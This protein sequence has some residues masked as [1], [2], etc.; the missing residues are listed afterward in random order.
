MAASGIFGILNN[1]RVRTRIY[2][3]FGII[4][5]LMGA[6]AASGVVGLSSGRDG[7][8]SV[9]GIAQLN[10][11]V[12]D[13]EAQIIEM[14][15]SVQEYIVSGN[16]AKRQEAET[17]RGAIKAR[18]DQASKTLADIQ[19][20]ITAMTGDVSSESQTKTS[21]AAFSPQ[22]FKAVDEVMEVYGRE[23]Q[24]VVE[25]RSR[26]N[27]IL[28]EKIDQAGPAAIKAAEEILAAEE[29]VGNMATAAIAA[30]LV[31]ELWSMS[32]NASRFAFAGEQ[33]RSNA[34]RD[35][36]G[37]IDQLVEQIEKATKADGTKGLIEQVREHVGAFEGGFT[38]MMV[39]N[40]TI[41][42]FIQ[43]AQGDYN[44]RFAQTIGAIKAS[45]LGTQAAVE[46]DT[47]THLT[48][49]LLLTYLLCGACLIVGL[50]SAVLVVR[51][52]VGPVGEISK[53]MTHLADGNL[54]VEIPGTGQK[55]EFGDMAR[56]A[57]VF[58]ANAQQT[59]KLVDQVTQSARQVALASGQAS[60]AVGQVS[61][62]SHT[63]LKALQQVAAALEQS[64]Q[65]IANVAES[66]QEASHKAKKAARLVAEGRQL[67]GSMV[68]EVNAISSN[69]GQ[70]SKITDAI[71]RIANQTNMLS[72]N[73]AIEAA[74]AG[75]YGRGFAV[76][77]EEI[78]KLAEHSGQ[79]AQEIA[80]L[81]K[82]A[83]DQAQ[84]G[85]AGAGKV[86]ANMLDIAEAVR[87]NDKLI[88][89][90]ATA[91]EEQQTTVS[92]IN[93]NVSELTRIGQSNAA[94]SEEITATMIDLSRL[95]EQTR[96]QAESFN[97]KDNGHR[98]AA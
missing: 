27:G 95:A 10:N 94:A 35:D 32:Y 91:M 82:K 74:R 90:I 8:A 73:A 79:L 31:S 2:G 13:I 11:L 88:G 46:A 96:G 65:A 1:T 42:D 19:G 97:N 70:I 59:H 81:V 25:L 22:Q 83:T 24:E 54:D 72:L 85:V 67:M 64:T 66:S 77:A 52:I 33:A 57:E 78:R 48:D 7:L 53:A 40:L 14:R 23:F 87:K 43:R 39:G 63:Q 69:T 17:Q 92:K 58:K 98:E 49:A 30:K 37:Q 18:I 62:G 84:R 45:S 47:Q 76:V 28:R 44:Q 29:K 26:K 20:R 86:S 60:T 50:L 4:L 41:N 12:R 55:D 36:I 5:A 16:A 61:D 21:V 34:M 51:S 80:E 89:A 6:N 15:L 38:E 9:V 56:S 68:E 93:G 71:S 3:A 75:E